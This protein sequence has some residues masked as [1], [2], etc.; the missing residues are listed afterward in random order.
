LESILIEPLVAARAVHFAA[1]MMLEGAIV[2][3]F[4]IADPI[5]GAAGGEEQ[6]VLRRLL[7]WTVW[8]GLL[9]GVVS[10]AAWLILLAGR[11]RGLAPAATL[12]QG[13]AW[14]VLTQTRFGETWQVRSVLAALLAASMFALS[15]GSQNSERWYGV[16]SI[17]LAASLVGA[18]AWAGHGAATPDAIGDVQLIADVSHL[19]AAG[20]WVGGLGP[21]TAMLVTARRQGDVRSIAIAAEAT[22]RFS[23]LGVGSVLTLLVTGMVNTYVLAGSVPALVGTPYGRLLLIKIGLFIAMVSIAAFNRQGLTPRL[24]SVPSAQTSMALSTL[25]ALVRNSLAE[26]ALGLAILVVVGAL[27][28]LIPGLHDQPVWPFPVRFSTDALGDPQLR[29]S[30]FAALSAIVISALLAIAAVLWRRLRWPGIICALV[31]VGYFAPTLRELTEPAYPTSFY[32]SPTGYS[33]QSIA[34]GQDLFLEN[35]VAC[36]G[37][38]GRGDGPAAQSLTKK[39]ADLTAEHIYGHPDGDIFW[40]ITHGKKGVMPAFGDVLDE[41]ARWNLIDF[42]HANADAVRLR[43]AAGQVNSL[44]YPMPNFSIECPDGSVVSIDELKDRVLHLVFAGPQAADRLHALAGLEANNVMRI[45]VAPSDPSSTASTCIVSDPHVLQVFAL[46][47]GMIADTPLPTEWLVDAAGL[48]RAIWYFGNG[49]PWSDGMTLKHRLDDIRRI[50][51]AARAAGG[52]A[53]HH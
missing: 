13:V 23:V 38:Q 39:P 28:I 15:R 46:Y 33:A 44:A 3:R 34:R 25:A 10:G 47:R 5:L 11:I 6:R 14:I 27:G 19:I 16:I 30:I 7:A 50:S 22:R 9:V 32:G 45:L 17:V 1:M 21:L 48:L 8:L 42:I 29:N 18:L 26:L 24:A 53:H 31:L 20:I 12:S 43:A 52:H 41:N 2:F 35:C 36:H 37:P 51:A 40:W 4:L 49:E